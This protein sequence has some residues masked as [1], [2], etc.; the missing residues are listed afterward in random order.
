MDKR[1]E[2]FRAGTWFNPT[3]IDW[4]ETELAID[5]KKGSGFK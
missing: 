4:M 5:C 1:K 2:K 3:V